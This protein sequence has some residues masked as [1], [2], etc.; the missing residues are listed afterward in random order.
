MNVQA[1]LKDQYH[2]SLSMLKQAIEECPDDL[3]AGSQHPIAFWRVAYHTLFFTHLYLQPGVQSFRPW[4]H[5][6]DEHQFLGPLPEPP[7]RQPKI[8]EPYTKQQIMDYWRICDG[9][10]DATVDQLDLSSP[11]SGFPWYQM[12]K[13]DHQIVNI[14]HIQ[15]HTAILGSRLRPVGVDVKWRGHA[16]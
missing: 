6:R 13:L 2:A 7:H 10:V 3:W 16:R 8:G 4:E 14:R 12:P 9:M 5:H 15:H 1:A 11:E